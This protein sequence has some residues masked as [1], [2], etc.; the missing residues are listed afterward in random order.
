MYTEEYERRG[1]PIKG[2]INVMLIGVAV[3][4]LIWSYPKI[5]KLNFAKKASQNAGET[6][7]T[8][9]KEEKKETKKEENTSKYSQTF[10][11]NMRR[12]KKI[13]LS[14]YKKYLPQRVGDT[15]KLTLNDMLQLKMLVPLV[16]QDNEEYDKEESYYQ[17]TNIG[18]EYLMKLN[19]KD[20]KE[21]AYLWIYIGDYNYCKSFIDVC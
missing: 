9:S 7:A 1:F 10:I 6:I 4:L 16:N 19:L 18:D 12:Y 17:I 15:T 14:N 20:S 8:L 3:A 5:S 21:E 11:E 13:V 2:I